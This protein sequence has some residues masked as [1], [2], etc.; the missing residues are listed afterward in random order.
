MPVVL[1]P[2]QIAR[3]RALERERAIA[4]EVQ[5]LVQLG[6]PGRRRRGPSFPVAT[7]ACPA[8]RRNAGTAR[9]A[10][11]GARHRRVA[12]AGRRSRVG[13]RRRASP[14][15]PRRAG[16]CGPS[17]P[18]HC[19]GGAR[20]DRLADALVHV[21]VDTHVRLAAQA[22]WVGPVDVRPSPPVQPR[23]VPGDTAEGASPSNPTG[24]SGYAPPTW[25]PSSPRS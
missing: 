3:P 11:R 9:A 12:A 24:W 1:R 14:A 18:G 25:P 15:G 5:L 19:F 21:A 20:H 6:P 4:V 8:G 22:L 10:P 7:T 23:R 16:R 2:R 17:L 13:R